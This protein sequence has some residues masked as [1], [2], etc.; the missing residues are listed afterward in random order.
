MS[1]GI[2]LAGL[3][4]VRACRRSADNSTDYAAD[5]CAHSNVVV[6]PGTADSRANRS[7]R[8]SATDRACPR[9]AGI[10][11][12]VRIAAVIV[13]QW[14]V[15]DGV[16]VRGGIAG[17]RVI[18]AIIWIGPVIGITAV[19]GI[20]TPIV[21]VIT[22]V[23]AAQI[24]KTYTPVAAAV[25]I[26]AMIT[27]VMA[28]TMAIIAVVTAMTAAMTIVAVITSMTAAMRAAVSATV[29]R[30]DCT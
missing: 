17:V 20:V 30:V 3:S 10:S 16:R 13:G 25:A 26:I 29:L 23:V 7:A 28:S 22:A 24:G 18:T 1:L 19:V 15:I 12:T 5:R 9:I 8:K 6:V 21:G 4:T 14:R 27:S 11:V 2:G